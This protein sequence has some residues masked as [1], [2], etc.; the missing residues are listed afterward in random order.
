MRRYRVAVIAGD[1]VGQEVIPVGMRVLERAAGAQGAFALEWEEFPWGSD[2][3]LRTGRMMPGEA[4][5]LL[6]EFDAI[7]LGAVGSPQVPDHVTLWGLLLPIRQRFNQYVNIR[8]IKLLAGVTSPLRDRGPGEIDMVCVRENSEGEYSGVGGRV[9]VGFDHEV[10]LQTDV[11]TRKGV[12]Q[13]ARYAFE[14]ARKRR[15]RLTSVTKS[16]ASPYSFVFWDEVVENVG[17]DYTDVE[18]TRLLVDAAAAQ[19]ITRP[20]DFDVLVTSNLFADILTDIGA[21]IQGGMGLAASANVNP[22]GGYPGMFEPVHGSAPDIAGTGRANPIGAVW[23][24][25]LM[26]EELGE[27]RAAR[28]VMDAIEAVLARGAVRTGDLGGSAGTN[29]VGDALVEVLAAG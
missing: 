26:L 28:A 20:A 2:F 6:A 15:R 10:A 25:A 9:H 1:G 13:V 3:Y 14:L 12:E 8:P 4:L 21:A 19:M 5:S 18:V 11:F 27:A 22:D 23:A 17:V 29:E 16:N 7:Y 24:G